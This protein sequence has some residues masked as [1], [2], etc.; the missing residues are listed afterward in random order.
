MASYEVKKLCKKILD[1]TG[2]W[3]DP[4]TFCPNRNR[5]EVDCGAYPWSMYVDTY[6]SPLFA[7]RI[8]MDNYVGAIYRE[9]TFICFGTEYMKDCLDVSNQ[10]TCR[11]IAFTGYSDSPDR[12]VIIRTSRVRK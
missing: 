8:K 6:K 11:V 2:I 3:C 10:L 7:D 4:E 5:T 9:D 1:Q 12:E